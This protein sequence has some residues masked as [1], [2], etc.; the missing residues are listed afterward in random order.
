M[1]FAQIVML[2][3]A[4]LPPSNPQLPLVVLKTNVSVTSNAQISNSIT[5]ASPL[6][7]GYSSWLGT[8]LS[9]NAVLTTTAPGSG[10]GS[11]FPGT[12]TMGGVGIQ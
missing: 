4:G 5:L 9:L 3:F 10:G 6:G 12:P 2:I 11:S 8:F 1:L 7:V